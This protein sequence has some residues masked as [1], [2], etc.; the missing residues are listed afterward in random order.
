MAADR[1]KRILAVLALS[2][3]LVAHS[4]APPKDVAVGNY[5]TNQV[6][7]SKG[8]DDTTANIGRID[9]PFLTISNAVQAAVAPAVVKVAPGL[10]NESVILRD[11]VNIEMPSG[12]IVSQSVNGLAIL[13]DEMGRESCRE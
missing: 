12:V 10:Y 8:G 6:Y 11:S 2:L 7:V 13:F 3:P 5:A 9:L 1:M 4:A